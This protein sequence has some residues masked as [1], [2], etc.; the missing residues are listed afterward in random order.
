MRKTR[1]ILRA[2][3]AAIANPPASIEPLESRTLLS[4]YALFPYAPYSGGVNDH[5]SGLIFDGSGGF[6]AIS[7]GGGANH[8][9]AVLHIAANS[10]TI[11]LVASF[12]GSNG[13]DPQ[14]DLLLSN[15]VLYGTTLEGGANSDGT[16]WQMPT[17]TSAL[18]ALASFDG[19]DGL[20]AN[21]GLAIDSSGD[22]YGTTQNGGLAQGVDNRNSGTLFEYSPATQQITDIVQFD[23]TTGGSYPSSGLTDDGK[24]DFYGTTFSGLGGGTLFEYTPSRQTWSVT[25]RSMPTAMCSV[26]GRRP[27]TGR[28]GNT[29]HPRRRFPKSRP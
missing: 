7:S 16:I 6:Y 26:T 24:G 2:R 8:D 23:G 15:G 21:G 11:D 1:W 22:L 10:K 3:H 14:G 27:A 19:S 4:A 20:Q 12:D 17:S 9:G 18:T 5:L 13:Q 28:F 25:W 29:M